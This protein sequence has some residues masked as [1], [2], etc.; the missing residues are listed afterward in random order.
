M[1]A[2]R[3]FRPRG[4]PGAGAERTLPAIC[5]DEAPESPRATIVAMLACP[6][7][8]GP[9]ISTAQKL[10]SGPGV[11]ATCRTCGRMIGVP[12]GRWLLAFLPFAVPAIVAT[13]IIETRAWQLRL[14]GPRDCR[15]WDGVCERET[16]TR[17]PVPAVGGMAGEGALA[18][19]RAL[20][21]ADLPHPL[22]LLDRARGARRYPSVV[23]DPATR[24]ERAARGRRHDPPPPRY[25]P[26]RPGLRGAT[27]RGGEHPAAAY[28]SAPRRADRARP[29]RG[30]R[31][32]LSRSPSASCPRTSMP[33]CGWQTCSS[34]T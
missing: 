23:V 17:S 1:P 34:A 19:R 3:P 24:P 15:G 14:L 21:T 25:G 31:R 9:G 16:R 27:H 8:G 10:R 11:P 30:S 32:V 7:C 2:G 33:D 26:C 6:H 20:G 22:A 29:V 5:L 28:L 18:G 12:S 4:R 13:E